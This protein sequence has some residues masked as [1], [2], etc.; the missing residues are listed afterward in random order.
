MKK[1]LT[2]CI[3]VALFTSLSAYS[4]DYAVLL[5]AYNTRVPMSEFKDLGEVREYNEP[6]FYKYYWVGFRSEAD[7][8]AAAIKAVGKGFTYAAA[9]DFSAL[10]RMKAGCCSPLKAM[11]TATPQEEVSLKNVFFD[12][13]KSNIT[14]E[15]S[16][17][18]NR[19]VKYL[20]ANPDCT[21][22]LLAHTDAKGTDGYNDALSGRRL[23]SVKAYLQSKGVG[24][25]RISGRTFGEGTPVAKNQVEGGVDAPEGRSLNRRVE[26]VAKKNGEIVP[27]VEIIN[28]PDTLK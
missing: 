15:S 7:A 20:R 22:E 26:L 2:L 6:P 3:S 11:A 25:A 19:W 4:Q 12:F 17:T 27:I 1:I 13:D 14:T 9:T 5:A 10:Q 24:S 8:Q 18:L 28:V 16:T 23:A 21:V